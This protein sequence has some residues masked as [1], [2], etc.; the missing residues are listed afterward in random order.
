MNVWSDYLEAVRYGNYVARLIVDVISVYD[1][2]QEGGLGL[3]DLLE[4]F[5]RWAMIL[6]GL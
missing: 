4:I 5:T 2:T 1:R 3:G 6:L